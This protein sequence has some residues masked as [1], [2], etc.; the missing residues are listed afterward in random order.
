MRSGGLCWRATFANL[1]TRSSYFDTLLR[2]SIFKIFHNTQSF[3]L[4]QW[5][6]GMQLQQ[7]YGIHAGYCGANWQQFGPFGLFY[8][9]VKRQ[10]V[11]D[12]SVAL[13]KCVQIFLGEHGTQYSPADVTGLLKCIAYLL[14]VWALPAQL[15][16]DP[17]AKAPNSRIPPRPSSRRSF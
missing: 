10:A 12:E 16:K 17:S 14:G 3:S 6:M 8:E 9:L 13:Q 2:S 11:P 1:N 15:V 4:L 7:R 5:I